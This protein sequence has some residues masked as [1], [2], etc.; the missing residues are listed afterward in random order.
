MVGGLPKL[1]GSLEQ[2]RFEAEKT[3]TDGQ[4][5]RGQEFPKAAELEA[6]RK[7]VEDVNTAITEAAAAAKETENTPPATPTTPANTAGPVTGP[8]VPPPPALREA[9]RPP[10]SQFGGFTDPYA[11][12]RPGGQHDAPDRGLGR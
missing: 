5:R 12:P 11:P 2:E 7:R 8:A 10:G 6:A 4:A 3:I 1:I 9:M